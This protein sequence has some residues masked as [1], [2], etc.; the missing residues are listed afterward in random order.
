MAISETNCHQVSVALVNYEC[1]HYLYWL[2]L[3]DHA[4]KMGAKLPGFR[5][6]Y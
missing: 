3:F 2:I 5:T 1:W 4:C 6:L